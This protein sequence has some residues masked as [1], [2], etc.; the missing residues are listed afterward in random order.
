MLQWQVDVVN[1]CKVNVTLSWIC[2]ATNPQQ[3]EVMEFGLHSF[4]D[5]NG[6]RFPIIFRRLSAN[7]GVSRILVWRG[8]HWGAEGKVT[9]RPGFSRTVLYFWVLSWISRCPVFV[10]YL[11]S[12]KFDQLIL[13]KVIKVVAIS[14]PPDLLAGLSGPTSKG[15]GL[16]KGRRS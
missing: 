12:T 15:R 13:S 7:C 11:K 5:Y 8:W 9:T 3:I 2:C 16:G 4:V 10:L 14:A 1:E 6:C